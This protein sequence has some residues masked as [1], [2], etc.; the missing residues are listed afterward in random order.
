MVK[1]N[2]IILLIALV[3]CNP[4]PKQVDSSVKDLMDNAITNKLNEQT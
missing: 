4:R 2:L 3:A 1:R